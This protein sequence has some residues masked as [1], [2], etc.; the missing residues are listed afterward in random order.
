MDP[1]DA[2][3]GTSRDLRASQITSFL[4]QALAG[5][6]ETV[7]VL[8]EKACAAGLLAEG[9]SISDAKLFKSAKAALGIRSRRI[10]F[11]Q[12]A[13]WVWILPAPCV[14]DVAAPVV[15]SVVVDGAP[16]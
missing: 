9:Q 1:N 3:Q 15:R 13:I 6:E 12:G 16:P 7:V 5:G 14:P 4:T 2:T 11:G 8:Q 10:G